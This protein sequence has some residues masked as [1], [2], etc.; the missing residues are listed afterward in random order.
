M[1][2][3]SEEKQISDG[4]LLTRLEAVKISPSTPTDE[5]MDVPAGYNRL[6]Q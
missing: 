5:T 1:P 6:D 4:K 2:L 3:L